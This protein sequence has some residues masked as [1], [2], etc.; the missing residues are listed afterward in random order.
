MAVWRAVL[1][2]FILLNLVRL[3]VFVDTV[4]DLVTRLVRW[5]QFR[6]IRNARNICRADEL[7]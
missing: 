3:N 5:I 2:A 1:H 6:T 4:D 7:R